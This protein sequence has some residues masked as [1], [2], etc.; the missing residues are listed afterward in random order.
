MLSRVLAYGAV[1]WMTELAFTVVAGRPKLPSPWMLPLYGLAAP[2]FPSVR[3]RVRGM[4][5]L[6]RAVAYGAALIAAEYAAG[7]LLRRAF[8]AAPWDYSGAR[9]SVHGATRLDYFP[10][11]ALYGVALERVDDRL[12]GALAHRAP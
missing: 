6:L 10:L 4:P 9:W 7:R 5:V 12:G 1:G 2:L 8:G 11:W 3:D